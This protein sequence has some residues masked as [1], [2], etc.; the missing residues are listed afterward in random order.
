MVEQDGGFKVA[1]RRMFT[2][3]GT[4][5]DDVAEDSNLKT[6]FQEPVLGAGQKAWEKRESEIPMTFETLVLS[7]STTAMF[8]L[9]I[10]A[11][12]ETGKVEK[13]LPRAKQTI[14]ILEI[15]KEKTK[16]NLNAE[17]AQLLEASVYD[18]KMTY[19]KISDR[20]KL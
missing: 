18:L 16:G 19:L 10:V 7:L 9:G 2:E 17:E 6:G 4:L 8:Q 5:R 20:I 15:L 14:D 13:D 3:D 1:D 12:P 11:S